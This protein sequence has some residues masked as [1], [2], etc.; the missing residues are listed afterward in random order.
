MS[1]LVTNQT[2]AGAS[3]KLITCPQCQTQTR[4][5]HF[6]WV[7]LVC[8]ACKAPVQKLEWISETYRKNPTVTIEQAWDWLG[9]RGMDIAKRNIKVRGRWALVR[10]NYVGDG[11]NPAF[12]EVLCYDVLSGSIY[13][14]PWDG[15]KYEDSPFV[16]Y[17]DER[18]EIALTKI[19]QSYAEETD[20]GTMGFGLCLIALDGDCAKEVLPFAPEHNDLVKTYLE[21]R[22]A[23][24]MHCLSL[25]HISEPTRPY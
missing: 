3:G 15:I 7:D 13:A 1:N 17:N 23:W 21:A 8:M 16:P 4:V 19:E 25:I 6:S 5:Y 14:E 2:R 9:E 24:R 11:W 10:S 12:D 20:D 22:L 18:T